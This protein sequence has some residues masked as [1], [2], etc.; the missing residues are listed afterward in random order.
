LEF[1]TSNKQRLYRDKLQIH[2]QQ[3]EYYIEI[4]LQHLHSWAAE[5][6][7]LFD[8]RTNL[9]TMPL[10]I[11]PIFEIAIQNALRMLVPDDHLSQIPPF[12]IVV[13]NHDMVIP[14][15]QLQGNLINKVVVI[16]GI[17]VSAFKPQL[18]ATTL[19]LRCRNCGFVTS[20]KAD[21]MSSYST[22]PIPQKC[23][24]SMANMQQDAPPC[25]TNPFEII[26]DE[27]SYIDVQELKLQEAPEMVPSGEMPRQVKLSCTRWLV[28]KVKPGTRVTCIG[29]Y[30]TTSGK[31]R[32]KA[33]DGSKAVDFSIPYV[34]VL[35]LAT[36][37][38]AIQIVGGLISDEEEQEL[39]ELVNNSRNI[40]ERIADSIA[41]AIMGKEDV[42]KAIACSL[43]G[44]TQKHLADGMTL[45]G[46]INVLLLGDPS[47]A[48]SQFLKFSSQVAPISVY[49]SG[50]GSS[51]AGLTASVVR[52]QATGDFNL[53]AGAL[54]LADGGLVCIDE[55]DKMRDQDRVAIHEAMEQQTIS[56]A[57][58]GITTVL[59]SRCS[60]LAAAN[61]VF[62]R[63]DDMKS[64]TEN[65]DFQATILS[66]FDLIFILRDIQEDAMDESLATHLINV[67]KFGDQSNRA[68]GLDQLDFNFT[69]PSAGT[70]A[71]N[72]QDN[73]VNQQPDRDERI[74]PDTLKKLIAFS[75]TFK[76]KLSQ[77][78]KA[79]IIDQYVVHRAS[80]VQN[81]EKVI[82][83]TV[84]QLEAMI[85]ISEAI[86]RMSLATEATEHHVAEAIRLFNVATI[87]ASSIS[88][89][90]G[91]EHGDAIRQA[92]QYALQLVQVNQAVST[93]NV[94]NKM[95]E[96]FSSY[97]TSNAVKNLVNANKLEYRNRKS[98][99]IRRA[100]R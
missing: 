19:K 49:T 76:P 52:S 64:A 24:G 37:S 13:T 6:S 25:P 30:T 66:R 1:E 7:P 68:P 59:N 41:P 80:A 62:G 86:A 20:E 51:A 38:S 82:P 92:E 72:N 18:K 89:D 31:R 40:Y 39:R 94:L 96:R 58:A 43:F 55:F 44:G 33:N 95:R 70:N 56:I 5:K 100:E 23:P 81:G 10:T 77:E 91:N 45:R 22:I 57:K 83:I 14:M 12:Q 29:I 9:L 85:R 35:G 53:E 90:G 17:V 21:S 65:I 48:K 28:D 26:G 47:V 87:Q 15:S 34:S 11:V 73:D 93:L 4:D 99:L 27:C 71:G 2:Y 75:R 84:R 88:G 78:A 97:V 8:M 60:V 98:S 61:P 63:Y 3:Q 36:D 50:K 74:P 69:N 16:Q 79:K 42:K 54:V 32:G 46:D 67:H